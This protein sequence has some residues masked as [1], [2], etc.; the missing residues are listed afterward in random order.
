MI[1]GRYFV[2]VMALSTFYKTFHKNKISFFANPRLL[3]ALL[4]I[5]LTASLLFGLTLYVV[6]PYWQART[7]IQA[8]QQNNLNTAEQLVPISLLQSEQ[9]IAFARSSAPLSQ[10]QGEGGKYIQQVWPALAAQQ[11]PHQLLL[12]QVDSAA[13][14]GMKHAYSRFP[15]R[16]RLTLGNRPENTLWF[17]WTRQSWTDWRLS[18]LCVYNPQPLADLNTCASS[19]R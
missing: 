13:Q 17:E 4:V 3:I 14:S 5:F 19:S 8:L 2:A 16:F 11:N 18:R 15:S 7:F 9:N 10:W 12:L 1:T 6:S